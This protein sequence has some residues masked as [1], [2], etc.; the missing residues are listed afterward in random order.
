MTIRSGKCRLGRDTLWFCASRPDSII[1]TLNEQSHFP[2]SKGE[3][4]TKTVGFTK[5]KQRVCSKL[6]K[7]F[8]KSP[9]LL[10]RMRNF[11]NI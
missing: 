6:T 3:L 7:F 4:T 5:E 10:K 9:I 1:E 8:K 2:N 11:E